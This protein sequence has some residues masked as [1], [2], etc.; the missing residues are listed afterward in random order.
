[1]LWLE[2]VQSQQLDW[3]D[4]LASSSSLSNVFASNFINWMIIWKLCLCAFVAAIISSHSLL[5]DIWI[6]LLLLVIVCSFLFFE[7]VVHIME[8]FMFI[9]DNFFCVLSRFNGTCSCF[10]CRVTVCQYLLMHNTWSKCRSVCF[11][12]FWR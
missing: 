9:S 3:I 8:G 1:M 2:S 10:R 12:V 5:Q 4:I 11:I 7:Y 6:S